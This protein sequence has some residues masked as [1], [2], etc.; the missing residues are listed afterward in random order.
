MVQLIFSQSK[1]FGMP[2]LQDLVKIESINNDNSKR[3]M[4]LYLSLSIDNV[5]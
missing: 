5:M 2:G 1:E 4:F 3:P